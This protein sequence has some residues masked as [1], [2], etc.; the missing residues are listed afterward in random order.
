MGFWR[1]V[2]LVEPR[3]SVLLEKMLLLC[4]CTQHNSANF[5][6]TRLRAAPPWPMQRAA[7]ANMAA[8]PHETGVASLGA[9]HCLAVVAVGRRAQ[10]G[11]GKHRLASVWGDG[12][13]RPLFSRRG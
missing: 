3:G 9:R 2:L 8:A 1:A 7:A 6:E 12:G 11:G 5:Q 4:V 10:G 13:F